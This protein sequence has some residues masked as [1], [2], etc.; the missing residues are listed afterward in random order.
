M[1]V[2]DS[3]RLTGKTAPLPV[4]AVCMASKSPGWSGGGEGVHGQ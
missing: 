4:P 2:I 1:T 3:F